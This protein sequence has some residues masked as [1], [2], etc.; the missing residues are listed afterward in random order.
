M[1]QTKT[2]TVSKE[3]S[4]GDIV[5]Q[6]PQAVEV[7]SSF[8]VNCVGCGTDYSLSLEKTAKEKGLSDEKIVQLVKTINQRI[9]EDPLPN[10]LGEHA[11]IL[12]LSKKAAEK[13]KD[14]MSKQESKIAGLRFGAIPG[15]CS[16]FTY[17]LTF[18]EQQGKEDV[19]TESHGI[20]FFIHESHLNL[21]RGT[22]IDF[23]D[24]LQGSGFKIINPN[25]KSTCGCGQS[26]S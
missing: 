15:G 16:G 25:A 5:T 23:V 4:V 7:L 3:M 12:S 18:E 21:L 13:I 8:G 6:H 9:A 10:Q 22:Q 24:A 19:V 11:P 2:I 1:A 26:F 14:L 20:K 17:S